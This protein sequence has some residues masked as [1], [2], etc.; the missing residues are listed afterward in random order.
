MSGRAETAIARDVLREYG[1]IFAEEEE[2]GRK[3]STGEVGSGLFESL[4]TR[5]TVS[6]VATSAA[7]AVGGSSSSS[8][9]EGRGQQQQPRTDVT[10]S[11]QYLFAN[12]AYGLAV[13]KVADEVVGLMIEAFEKRAKEL[14]YR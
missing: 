4:V 8:P 12:P 9:I 13:G 10:L 6:P 3:R 5:W 11:I 2:E 14:C 1:Y 7:A